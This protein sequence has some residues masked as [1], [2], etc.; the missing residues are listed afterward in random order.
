MTLEHRAKTPNGF[1]GNLFFEELLRQFLAYQFQ[2]IHR[3]IAAPGASLFDELFARFGDDVR[4]QTRKWF[5]E[6]TNIPFTINYPRD[7]MTIPFVCVVNASE[8][9]KSA[10]TY[11]ADH[12]GEM[13][14]GSHSVTS[15]SQLH[16]PPTLYGDVIAVPDN[17][18]KA[19]QFRQV[20]SVPESRTTKIYIATEN[21][22]ATLY[23]YTAIK[24]LILINKM[25]FDEFAGARNMKLN[26]NDLEHKPEL[27]PTFAIF[28]V[29]TL[30]YDT[31]FD[32]ALEPD[33][34]IGGVNVSLSAFI[35]GVTQGVVQ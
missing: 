15:S 2:E 22:N 21:P 17:R 10:E 25:D 7:N 16:A 11:L 1:V 20:I 23:L 33:K 19:T 3:D 29:L 35:N 4:L 27:F 18:P 24:A 31:N 30:E 8:A 28:K 26:G 34:T 6:N 32:I 5:S 9:E 12:G 14:L 13:V